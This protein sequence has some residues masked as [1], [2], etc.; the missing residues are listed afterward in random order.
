VD[1]SLEEVAA[2][3]DREYRSGRY[4]QEP[5]V[6]FV[7]DIVSVAERR[8]LVPGT[9][10]YIGCGNGRNYLALVDAGLDLIGL[11][12]SSTALQEL[13]RRVPSRSDRLVH[14]DLSALPV[15]RTFKT[16]VGIQ[17]FQHGS[18]AF[19]HEHIRSAQDRV[20]SGGILAMRVNAVGTD[21]EFAHE[22]V[23]PP[24]GSG[25]TVR[26]AEG[27]KAGLLVHFFDRSEVEEL[28]RGAFETALPIRLDST[29]REPPRG[30]QWSQWQ[31][32][33]TRTK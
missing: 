22:V 26:Y 16:V 33:W 17:V 25:F 12:V 19:C 28:F 30:G 23:E 13:A 10:L 1:K 8:G 7:R 4:L 21:I 20:H 3:W 27:P 18:R 24:D 14:G 31:G 32:I 6:S 2:A 29:F 11:D 9:G 5:P 15:A